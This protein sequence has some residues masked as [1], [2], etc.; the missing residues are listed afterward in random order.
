MIWTELAQR[1][2]TNINT[3]VIAAEKQQVF[4]RAMAVLQKWY[5]MEAR[6]ATTARL[7]KALRDIEKFDVEEDIMK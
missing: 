7:L 2:N 5:S 4:D 1:L 6:N 3:E